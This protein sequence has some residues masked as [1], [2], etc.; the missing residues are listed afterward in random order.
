MASKKGNRVEYSTFIS[1]GKDSVIGHNKIED[2]GKTFVVKVWCK[3]SK[4]KFTV[5]RIC[6]DTCK[7][8]LRAQRQSQSFR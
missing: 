4:D 8:L 7:F 1:W 3:D 6:Q 2:N 5:E